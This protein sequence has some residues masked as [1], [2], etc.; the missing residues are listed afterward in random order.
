[1]TPR[2]LFAGLTAILLAHCAA[3]AAR[4][5]TPVSG[6]I[7][8]TDGEGRIQIELQLPDQPWRD[9]PTPPGRQEAF[10][11]PLP[12]GYRITKV[13]TFFG[14]DRGHIVE[15]RLHVVAHGHQLV[16]RSEH[17]ETLGNYDS[18]KSEVVDYVTVTG[19]T[20]QTHLQV[21]AAGWSTVA[22]LTANMHFGVIFELQA[23]RAR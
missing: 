12:A 22:G 21:L 3:P 14:V 2:L 17:K 16:T 4:A 9:V 5:C 7:S 18:W 13:R 15:A 19:P 23:P 1:V 20:G 10:C 6:A 11:Y 8:P